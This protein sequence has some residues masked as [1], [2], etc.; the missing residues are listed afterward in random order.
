[1]ADQK[2]ISKGMS[3]EDVARL[4][5]E[6]MQHHA[7]CDTHPGF[8]FARGLKDGCPFCLDKRAFLIF[9]AKSGFKSRQQQLNEDPNISS[10][11]IYD[12]PK[13]Q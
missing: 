13:D 9:Q 6:R 5:G 8:D 7:F 11:S 2:D 12:L 4:L 1:V 10:I 3:W